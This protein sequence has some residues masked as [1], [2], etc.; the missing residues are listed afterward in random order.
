MKID[1]L[2]KN[3]VSNSADSGPASNSNVGNTAPEQVADCPIEQ[4]ESLSPEAIDAILA[5]VLRIFAAR[6]RAIREELARQDAT[7]RVPE[8]APSTSDQ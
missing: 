7:Q 2:G 4:S 5:E 3:M 1:H 6:G 8:S